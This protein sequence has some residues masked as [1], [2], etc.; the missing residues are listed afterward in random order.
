M[1]MTPSSGRLG[2]C[3]V[4]LGCLLACCPAQATP[5]AHT[6]FFDLAVAFRAVATTNLDAAAAAFH[7]T[8]PLAVVLQ[9]GST[10]TPQQVWKTFFG[11]AFVIAGRVRS[12]RPVFAFYNPILDG[13]LLTQWG[14][15]AAGVGTITAASFA[16][17]SDLT[18]KIAVNSK[19]LPA[20]WMDGRSTPPLALGRALQA[21]ITTFEAQHPPNGQEVA[22]LATTPAGAAHLA[23]M[24]QSTTFNNEI[25]V[26]LHEPK[27][28]D[29]GD[30]IWPFLATLSAGDRVRLAALLPARNP[31]SVDKIL[32]I[33]A[34]LR[35]TMQA[36]HPVVTGDTCLIFLTSP[37]AP[38][39]LGILDLAGDQK[40][41]HIRSFGFF[42]LAIL[43]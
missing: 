40:G 2:G 8:R 12:P 7:A 5:Q 4:L 6:T 33:P 11:G 41:W 42:D 31:L 32:D 29:M 16:K 35:R 28:R 17:G 38:Q 20:A 43:K 23:V 39:F 19:T 34:E 18:G 3:A 1:M 10:K 13:V 26:A 14:V 21:F 37:G 9:S 25:L 24:V 30:R 36:V 15:D 27:Y 22:T